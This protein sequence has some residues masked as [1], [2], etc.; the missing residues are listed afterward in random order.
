MSTIPR[1][2]TFRQ[3]TPDQAAAY[4]KARGSY[5]SALY[6][7]ILSYHLSTGGS[8]DLLLDVGCGPGNATRDLAPDFEH[9]FGVDPGAEMIAAAKGRGSRTRSGEEVRFEVSS[10]EDISRVEG[11]EVGSVDLLIGAMTVSSNDVF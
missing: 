9:L 8:T 10:A 2:Q 3:Y 5:P 7:I 11:L 4:T 1:D 6:D